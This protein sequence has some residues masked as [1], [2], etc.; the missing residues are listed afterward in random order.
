MLYLLFS[1]ESFASWV[2]N[3]S[4]LISNSFIFWFFDLYINK[5]KLYYEKI[6][7]LDIIIIYN[8]NNIIEIFHI[9][10]IILNINN[11][12][13]I[14]HIIKYKYHWNISYNNIIKYK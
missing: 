14:L 4:I 1:S 13:E 12:I 6:D 8:I 3:K 10:I 5:I 2:F 7:I 11:I 9:I